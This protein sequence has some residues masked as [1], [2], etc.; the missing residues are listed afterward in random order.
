MCFVLLRANA[1]PSRFFLVMLLGPLTR[2][3]QHSTGVLN[4]PD[5]TSMFFL[6]ALCSGHEAST[7]YRS[8]KEVQ[9]LASTEY[10]WYAMFFFRCKGGPFH[11][12]FDCINRWYFQCMHFRK[13]EYWF[14]VQYN[15]GKLSFI[16]STFFAFSR[17]IFKKNVCFL[18]LVGPTFIRKLKTMFADNFL[19]QHY[20]PYIRRTVDVVLPP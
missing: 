11:Y 1:W 7:K 13:F 2:S 18:L 19:L 17:T 14:T 5:P 10:L 20:I 3:V 8:E 6:Y 12:M 15:Q 9:L 4:P 16:S